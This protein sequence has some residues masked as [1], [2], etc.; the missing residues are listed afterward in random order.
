MYSLILDISV[1]LIMIWGLVSGLLRGALI[2]IFWMLGIVMGVFIAART[3]PTISF[4]F[5]FL[6]SKIAYVVCFILILIITII[7]FYLVGRSLRK[8][9]K[10]IH[11]GFVDNL[12]GLIFGFLKGSII[13]AVIF[14][15]L[16]SFNT[17]EKWVKESFFS[18][19]LLNEVDKLKGL[20][21]ED[22]N[23]MIKWKTP[24][25]RRSGLSG[26]SS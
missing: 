24:V 10:L 14:I 5:S 23:D 20:F 21:P 12:F 13:A 16:S 17:T 18:N 15:I 1:L 9:L 3:Y 19:F 26:Q 4:L 11:I 22:V 6:P 2:E 7:I 25:E 8:Y